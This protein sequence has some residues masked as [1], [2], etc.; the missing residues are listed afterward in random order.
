[1]VKY[2]RTTI[3]EY[4]CTR[5]ISDTMCKVQR[6]RRKLVGMQRIF[7]LFAELSEKQGFSDVGVRQKLLNTIPAYT[8]HGFHPGIT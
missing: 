5:L 6:C 1:M 8:K 3:N 2:A 4:K 7:Y